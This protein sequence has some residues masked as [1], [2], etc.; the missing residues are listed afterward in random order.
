MPGP[1][2]WHLRGPVI[3]MLNHICES[4]GAGV[5]PCSVCLSVGG[6]CWGQRSSCEPVVRDKMKSVGPGSQGSD[7]PPR[8]FTLA[9]VR[10]HAHP[11]PPPQ[12]HTQNRKLFQPYLVIYNISIGHPVFK[13]DSNQ[14]DGLTSPVHS[15]ECTG[16]DLFSL[17]SDKIHL[18]RLQ[19]HSTSLAKVTYL[20]PCNN[21]DMYCKEISLSAPLSPTFCF[22][23]L[24]FVSKVDQL[25]SS[26]GDRL[27]VEDKCY[28]IRDWVSHILTPM[29]F[30]G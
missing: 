16:S 23:E 2:K 24:C 7:V 1:G 20:D 19:K 21:S 8:R 10:R 26:E 22:S 18:H 29:L 13:R 12:T 17:T 9:S 30:F 14:T 25:Q 15:A 4:E 3:S 5:G 28:F 11:P 27:I 6:Q